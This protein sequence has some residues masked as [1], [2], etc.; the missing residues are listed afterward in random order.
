[1]WV[2]PTPVESLGRRAAEKILVILLKMW[3]KI[4]VI[5]M[6]HLWMGPFFLKNWYLGLLSNSSAANPPSPDRSDAE[7]GWIFT[8][9]YSSAEG[10]TEL[11]TRGFAIG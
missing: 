5:A 11:F 8:L 4:G 10:K 1:M 7:K 3:A 9:V 6:I 2:P